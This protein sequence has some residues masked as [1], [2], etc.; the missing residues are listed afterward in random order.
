M[1]NTSIFKRSCMCVY[2]KR[3][4]HYPSV[5]HSLKRI[6]W[7]S[8]SIRYLTFFHHLKIVMLKKYRALA[9]TQNFR[10]EFDHKKRWTQTSI[11]SFK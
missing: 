9:G 6:L 10:S 3:Q 4:T 8:L 7:S 1:F 2:F 5:F 11:D